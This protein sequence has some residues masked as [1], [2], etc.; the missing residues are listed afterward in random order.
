MIISEISFNCLKNG[1][2]FER[3]S[4]E[5]SLLYVIFSGVLRANGS[6]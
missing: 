5:N 4:P 2:K 3:I 6:L 1:V